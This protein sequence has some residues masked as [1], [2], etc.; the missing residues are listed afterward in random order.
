M[1]RKKK[2]RPF[3]LNESKEVKLN[4]IVE[5]GADQRLEMPIQN[6][7]ESKSE[8]DETKLLN[9]VKKDQIKR[10]NTKY[11][12]HRIQTVL[13]GNDESNKK[14]VV[15]FKINQFI[16]N[17]TRTNLRTYKND[18]TE[19]F[20]D[21][22]SIDMESFGKLSTNIQVTRNFIQKAVKGF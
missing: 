22:N 16:D 15:Q 7:D 14:C 20:I 5:E 11:N 6:K 21:S 10:K 17:L 8:K 12:K 13:S 18:F 19:Y 3:K 9:I 2:E 4:V 1:D